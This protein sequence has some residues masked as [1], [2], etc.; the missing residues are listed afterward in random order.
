L[1]RYRLYLFVGVTLFF[2]ANVMLVTGAFVVGQK[3][4]HASPALDDWTT[5]AYDIGHSGYNTSE[6]ILNAS[7]ASKLKLQWSMSEGSTVSTQAAVANGLVYW[8]SWDGIEHATKADGSTAWTANLGVAPSNCGSSLGVASTATIATL[9]INGTATSV[10]FVGSATDQF[11]ALNALTGS[12]IWQTSLGTSGTQVLWASPLLY[13]GSVYIGIA[14]NDCPLVQAKIYQ[15]NATTGAIQN[16]YNV[17]PNGCQG[18]GVW[19]TITIDSTNNTLY[20]TTGN[21]GNC[22]VAETN[23]DGIVQLNA[24][25]LA[26]MSSW[27]VP[28]AQ[29]GNDLDFGATPTL[30][31]A[32]INSTVHRLVGAGGKNGNYYAFDEATISQGPL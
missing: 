19:G 14:S 15:L 9:S 4:V 17:V 31:T 6:T 18:A 10:D 21:P 25:T 20:F 2:L 30:F 11:Y 3:S 29:Q 5:Y 22:S 24:S 16:T 32:T 12:V 23:A 26:Y 1:Q 7:T 28:P 13:N 8:G 27:Q